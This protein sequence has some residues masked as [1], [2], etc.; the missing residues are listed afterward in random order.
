MTEWLKSR[1]VFFAIQTN[2]K[3]SEKSSSSSQQSFHRSDSSTTVSGST[4][5]SLTWSTTTQAALDGLFRVNME[6]V[7]SYAIFKSS[8]LYESIA[9]YRRLA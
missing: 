6:R 8:S 2:N 7:Y 1:K 3:L 9:E 5:S 4:G